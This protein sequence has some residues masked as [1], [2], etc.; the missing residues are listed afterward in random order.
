MQLHTGEGLLNCPTCNKTFFTQ[1]ALTGHMAVH[2]DIQPF[3]CSLCG[4]RYKHA[5][6]LQLHLEDHDGTRQRFSC[7]ECDRSFK[8]PFF[9]RTRFLEPVASRCDVHF[10]R[11]EG[12]NEAIKQFSMYWFRHCDV[13]GLFSFFSRF[14]DKG[15][16]EPAHE[17]A[18]W[19][20]PLPLRG[21]ASSLFV[22]YGISS[23]GTSAVTV[24]RPEE[25]C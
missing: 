17:A 9:F 21:T 3:E 14:P 5:K 18:Q 2:M 13:S 15:G 19:T 7:T 25:K 23:S 4:K 11:W 16:I 12:V 8:V 10:R 24:P 6:A 22:K 1:S 20:G